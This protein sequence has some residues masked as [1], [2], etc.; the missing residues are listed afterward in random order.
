MFASRNVLLEAFAIPTNDLNY[1]ATL[2]QGWKKDM[3]GSS[4]L[5]T[6]AL[7]RKFH[8]CIP[9]L[10]NCTPGLSSNFYMCLTW[11]ISYLSRIGSSIMGINK[12]LTDIRMWNLWHWPCNSFCGNFFSN[13]RYW[14][15]AVWW[16]DG[17]ACVEGIPST[18]VRHF[19]HLPTHS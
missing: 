3:R 14:F 18:H 9:F 16:S 5:Y 11:V 2:T 6:A 17:G 4:L 1:R 19:P 15:F 10:F 8:L 13:F 12:S 7:Q